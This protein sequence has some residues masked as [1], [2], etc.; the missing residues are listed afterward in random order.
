MTEE[1]LAHTIVAW[2]KRNDGPPRVSLLGIFFA[3]A[4]WLGHY[5]HGGAYVP[6]DLRL[7]RDELRFDPDRLRAKLHRQSLSW[8]VPLADIVAVTRKSGLA[9]DTIEIR[10]ARGVET[11]KA[12]KG[13]D[14]AFFAQLDAARQAAGAPA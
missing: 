8:S 5:M 2:L 12:I 9:M 1:A 11:I 10:H 6:G 3:P 13:R 14:K 4:R 7:M